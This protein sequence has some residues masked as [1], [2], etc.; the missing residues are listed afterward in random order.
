MDAWEF[1]KKLAFGFFG[2]FLQPYVNYFESIKPDLQR[3]NM[4]MSLTEYVYV[5]FFVLL[6]TFIIELPLIVVIT[7]ILFKSAIIAFIFSFSVTI[8]LLLGIFFLFFTYPSIVAN[9]R[10]KKIDTALPFA[11][12]YMATFASSGTAPP[13]M[14]KVLSKF[15]EYGEISVEAAKINRDVEAFGM[16]VVGAM[17]KTAGRTPS[18]QL[19]ELLWGMD[20]VIT[21]GGNLGDFLHE[22]SRLFIQDYRRSLQQY[23]QTLSLLIEIYLTLILVGSIFFVIMTALMSIFGGGASNLLISFVQF[24]VIFIGLPFISIGFIFLLKTISP[25]R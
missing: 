17:R 11:I 10:K 23:S 18:N 8:F 4:A 5:M 1:F 9:N 14:F 12:T 3:A 21:T 2:R 25:T 6:I 24:L 7:S 13:V 15:E 22:K 20:T 16:D 19:K